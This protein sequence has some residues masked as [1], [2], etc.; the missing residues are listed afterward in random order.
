MDKRYIFY[1]YKLIEEFKKTKSSFGKKKLISNSKYLL[2]CYN[3][4]KKL[5]NIT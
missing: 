1:R 3:D 2:I 4:L 5:K